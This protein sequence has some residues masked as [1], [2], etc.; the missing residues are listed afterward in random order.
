MVTSRAHRRPR[1][2]P[3][4]PEQDLLPDLRGRPRGGRRGGRRALRLRAGLVLPVLPRPGDDARPGTD[5]RWTSCSRPSAPR[6][7]PASGGRQ[8]PSHFGS[9]RRFNV[10][11]VVVADG[12]AVPPGGRRGGGRLQDGRRAGAA[13]SRGAWHDDEIVI[14]CTGDGAT[15]EGE[16]WES[17]NTACNLKLPLSSTCVQDNGY[18]ISVPIEVQTAGGSVSQLGVGLPRPAHRGV[19]RHGRGRHLPGGRGGHRLRP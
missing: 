12:H 13:S 1:D 17:L 9:T 10:P 3:E 7:I 18:A 5:T 6:P 4:A 15:S 14:V 19:R 2:Q 11:D 8:M 16:F